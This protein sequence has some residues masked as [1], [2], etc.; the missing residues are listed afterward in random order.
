MRLLIDT[1]IIL[2]FLEG[3]KQLPEKLY[4]LI[5][6]PNNEIYVSRVSYSK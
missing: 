3:S 5:S 1:Q 6:D 4:N 2:W